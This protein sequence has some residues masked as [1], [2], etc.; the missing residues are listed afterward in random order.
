MREGEAREEVSVTKGS[1][2]ERESSEDCSSYS[3][4][5]CLQ[6]ATRALL[7][8]L[9]LDHS[10]TSDHINTATPTPSRVINDE[11][12][13]ES[14]AFRY[15]ICTESVSVVEQ[16]PAPSSATVSDHEQGMKTSEDVAAA[17]SSIF[18]T[19]NLMIKRPPKPPVSS[20][21]GGQHN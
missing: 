2:Q 20:G 10:C 13:D 8:C 3:R 15:I 14:R 7:K 5:H 18:S 4:L 17:K 1:S 12:E 19:L 11:G 16:G 21:R 6:M 9:G